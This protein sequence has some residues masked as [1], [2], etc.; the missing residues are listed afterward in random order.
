MLDFL[1]HAILA[2]FN[3]F[4]IGQN[5]NGKSIFLGI[6]TEGQIQWIIDISISIFCGG[7]LLFVTIIF[8]VQI[9][10]LLKGMTTHRRFSHKKK[11]S[12]NKIIP[13]SETNSMLLKETGNIIPDSV[14]SSKINVMD[15]ENFT[16]SYCYIPGRN[17]NKF[18]PINIS[19]LGHN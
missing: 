15:Q 12:L 1:F 7:G 5:N 18:E 19:A 13:E 10:N 9:T 4:G 17:Q 14:R 2:V 3:Y 8:Y 11:S 6:H 16:N